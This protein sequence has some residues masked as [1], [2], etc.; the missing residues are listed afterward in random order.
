MKASDIMTRDVVTLRGIEPISRAIALMEQHQV[1]SLIVDRRHPED[2]YGL[3]TQS[4]IVGKIVALGKDPQRVRVY[5]VMTKPCLAINPDLQVE[6][7]ARLF[8]HY[9]V[10]VAPVIAGTLL[11]I[12]SMT[13]ILSKG[14]AAAPP[15]EERLDQQI[16]TA[17][18]YAQTICAQEPVDPQNCLTA[19]RL[20]EDLQ[21]EKA[22]YQGTSIAKTAFEEFRETNP[23]WL[24]QQDYDKWC[25]G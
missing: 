25:S 7:V 2:A 5:E 21:A 6:Y 16:Q 4:D 11:G 18:A 24:N 22:Y 8:A 17:I 15:Y 12:I 20:V 10:H 3:I 13:D 9:Q 14:I 1:R 23:R 19:W